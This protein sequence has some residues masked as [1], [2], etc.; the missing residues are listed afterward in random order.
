MV[1][2]FFDKE[3]GR[4]KSPLEILMTSLGIDL[5]KHTVSLDGGC[6]VAPSLNAFVGGDGHEMAL[7]GAGW[8]EWVLKALE[9]IMKE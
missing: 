6:G 8:L 7:Y 2:Q 5:G 9:L 1:I 4:F 3:H